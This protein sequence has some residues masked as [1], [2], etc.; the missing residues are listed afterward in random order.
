M[1]KE[2]L[3]WAFGAWKKG[4]GRQIEKEK[5]KNDEERNEWDGRFRKKRKR[6]I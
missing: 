6:T 4:V 5:K 1:K 2:E 3:S